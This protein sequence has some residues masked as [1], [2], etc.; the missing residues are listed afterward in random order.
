MSLCVPVLRSRVGIRGVQKGPPLSRGEAF[1]KPMM[2]LVLLP[3]MHFQ[4]LPL[5]ALCSRL[6]LPYREAQA[7][8][9]KEVLLTRMENIR[10]RSSCRGA[11]ETN[12]TSIHE[13]SGLIPGL[14]Q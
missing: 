13:D 5:C 6:S 1:V 4:A 2:D 9:G 3:A 10:G 8:G 11:A 12:L 7:V 14:A